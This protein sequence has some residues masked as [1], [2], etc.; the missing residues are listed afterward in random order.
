MKQENISSED[1]LFDPNNFRFQD[2]KNFIYANKER[3]HEESV[4]IRAYQRLKKDESLI[5][6]KKSI[7]ES[8]YIPIERL[9][10][11]FHEKSSKYIVI[12]GN[13][14]LAAV[15]WI[16]EDHLAGLEIRDELLESFK[17][18]PV[19]IVEDAGNEDKIFQYSLM[20]IRHVSSIKQWGGY[21]RAKLV[22]EMKD[23]SKLEL[24][25]IADRLGLTAK[26]V[27]RRYRA[28]KALEQMMDDEEYSSS[29]E[30]TMY[31]LFHE[32]VSL[33]AVKQWL[34]W[35]DDEY[36]FLNEED[37]RQFY[38]LLTPSTEEES[39][40]ER[41]P[42]ISTYSQVRS[43]RDILP[44]PEAKR[45]LLDPS[46]TFEEAMAIA[47]QETLSR[48]WATNVLHAI[49]SLERMG[50]QELK[51]LNEGDIGMLKTLSERVKERL[52]DYESLRG[53]ELKP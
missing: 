17:K 45:L 11:K 2:E 13:R 39:E 21:Q 26:E 37:L 22:S 44:R 32:A 5:A 9:V 41:S 15:K 40:E 50:V 12:E 29:A 4:Q 31:P 33:S 8:G 16:I 28:F 42:K 35:D 34:I 52:V 30:P 23:S 47:Q 48:K 6:L 7:L 51:S 14:R 53:P 1:L 36:K 49:S 43:L 18:L 25:E 24:S 20:G 27:N 46:S 10:V 38:G 3:Y 19:V